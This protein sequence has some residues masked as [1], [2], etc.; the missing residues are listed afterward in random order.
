MH[1]YFLKVFYGKINKKKY[2]LW[3]LEHNIYYINVITM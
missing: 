1:K 3:I 2:K